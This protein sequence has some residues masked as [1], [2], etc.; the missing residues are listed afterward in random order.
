ME[1]PVVTFISGRTGEDSHTYHHPRV[2]KI[3][4]ISGRVRAAIGRAG[5]DFASELRRMRRL[6][7]QFVVGA[8][9]AGALR[10]FAF[11]SVSLSAVHQSVA[12]CLVDVAVGSANPVGGVQVIW[13]GHLVRV[14]RGGL[15][16]PS[17]N[18]PV[19]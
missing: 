19:R 6:V 9:C 15:S 8:V 3:V 12:G 5:M 18:A 14:A 17:V 11:L 13:I 2:R 16:K 10:P 7:Q 4:V 1:R